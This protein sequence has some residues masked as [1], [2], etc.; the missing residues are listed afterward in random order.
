MFYDLKAV[1]NPLDEK[2]IVS[3]A[4]P[5]TNTGEEYIIKPKGILV[6]PET[7]A[8][9]MATQI[10]REVL[11]REGKEFDDLSRFNIEKEVLSHKFEIRDLSEGSIKE[12]PIEEEK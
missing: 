8:K 12:K 3:C 1:F 7:I 10:A 2:I 5:A 9:G 6:L 4:D 11:R